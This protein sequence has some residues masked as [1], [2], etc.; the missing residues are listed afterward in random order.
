MASYDGFSVIWRPGTN[1]YAEC[2]IEVRFNFLSSDLSR[3]RTAEGFPV[4]ICAKSEILN[5]GQTEFA[6]YTAE[7]VQA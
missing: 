6:Y 1:G 5:T 2:K 7:L 4:K 3:I